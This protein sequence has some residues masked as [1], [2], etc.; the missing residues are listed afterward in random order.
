MRMTLPSLRRPGYEDQRE[1]FSRKERE[2]IKRRQIWRT[3]EY[4]ALLASFV[5]GGVLALLTVLH[6]AGGERMWDRWVEPR[7]YGDLWQIALGLFAAGGLAARGFLSRRA[8]LE[9][10]KQY[11]SQKQI[12]ETASRMLDDQDSDWKPER[13]L[14]TLGD[15]ALQEQ[16]EW[17]WLRHTRPFEMPG[18]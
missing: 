13:I 14:E 4:L 7:E 17:L 12:F 16:S 1:W 6:T 2:C 5:T 3:I 9:L 11:A 10:T 18:P 15:E 8:Y